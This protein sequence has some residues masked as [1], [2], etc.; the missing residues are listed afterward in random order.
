MEQ[1]KNISQEIPEI[2]EN[3][4]K[5]NKNIA[6][7][8]FCAVLV[9][10]LVAAIYFKMSKSKNEF[11][12]ETSEIGTKLNTASLE[13]KEEKPSFN[14]LILNKPEINNSTTQMLS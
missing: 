11:K 13:F 3:N 12:T 6:V 9:I 1:D 14:E 4:A 2:A 10:M 7:I 8:G 5:S